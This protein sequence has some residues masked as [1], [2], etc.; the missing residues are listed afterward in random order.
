MAGGGGGSILAMIQTLRNNR[1][2]LSKRRSYFKRDSSRYA[3]NKTYRKELN[4]F[5]NRKPLSEVD[6]MKIR[7]QFNSIKRRNIVLTATISFLSLT[8]IIYLFYSILSE[9]RTI[10]KHEERINTIT[11]SKL[12]PQPYNVQMKLGILKM[13]EKDYFMASGNFK[14]ALILQPNDF[15]AE[16][17]LTKAYY[18]L[19]ITKGQACQKAQSKIK[20]NRNKFPDEYGFKYLE[21]RLATKY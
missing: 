21:E 5:K 15:A 2:L 1:A 4:S 14:K 16:Y 18:S 17:F 19:C 9:K 10:H 6:L 20:E 8:I 13:K 12:K 7:K 11:F 3:Y